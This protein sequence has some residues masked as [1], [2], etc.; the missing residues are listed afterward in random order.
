MATYRIWGS[1][2]GK[3][4]ELIDTATNPKSAIYLK[5]EYQMAFGKDWRLTIVPDPYTKF[6]I[7]GVQTFRSYK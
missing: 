7:Q 5:N 4:R 2:Q 3:K 6:E 1:Y